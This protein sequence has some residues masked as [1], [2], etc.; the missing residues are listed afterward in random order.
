MPNRL[1]SFSSFAILLT[2]AT[3]SY[4]STVTVN[5]TDVIYAAGSQSS[6]AAALGG[7]LPAGISLGANPISLSFS[8][9]TGSITLNSTSGNSYNNAD[10]FGAAVSQS[11]NTGYGSL[12]GLTAPEAGY[13]TGVFVSAGGPSGS[14]PA[15]L[16]FT[17]TN[18][19]AFTSISPLLDQVFFIGDGLTGNGIGSLQTFVVPTGAATLYL[20]ITDACGYNGAPSCYTDNVGAYSATYTIANGGAPT[21]PEPSSLILFGTGVVGL[22]AKL[23]RRRFGL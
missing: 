10:G 5:S 7:T 1:P 8:S 20:G 12:S 17:G 16:D 13:L 9:I 21:V 3:A 14:A 15:A 19:T 11:S 23:K 4:A 22:C 18:G 6:L 2:A